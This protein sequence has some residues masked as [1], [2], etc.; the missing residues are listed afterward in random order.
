MSDIQLSAEQRE[1]ALSKLKI[2]FEHEMAHTLGQFEAEFLLDF[3]TN[4]IGMHFYN[5]GL[6]DA[7][8]LMAKKLDDIQ[9][10]LYEMEKYT[11]V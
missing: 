2:Y 8:A 7:G 9:Q 10:H 11:D 1:L 6:L 5:Q 3:I 4:K